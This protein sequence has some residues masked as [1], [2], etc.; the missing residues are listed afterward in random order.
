MTTQNTLLILTREQD[1]F[2]EKVKALNLPNLK[3]L[4]PQNEAEIAEQIGQANIFLANPLL[5]YKWI[6]KAT[7][8]EWMQSTFAG[9]DAINAP[10]LRKDY[11]L[12]NVKDTYGV[13]MAEYVMAYILTFHRELKHYQTQQ[14]DKNWIQKNTHSLEGKVLGILGA[15]SIGKKIAKRAKA[16]GMKIIGYKKSPT[17]VEHFDEIETGE[18]LK[19]LLSQADYVINVLPNTK[20][21]IHIINGKTLQQMKSSAIFM[22]IGRGSAVDEKAIVRA[23]ETDQIAKA[24]LDVFHV[25]PL[26]KDSPLW[27]TKNCIITPHISGYTLSNRVFEI[28]AENYMRFTKKEPLN[29][30]IDLKKGY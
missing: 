13:V 12:T 22:N 18:G 28:F 20:E 7:N 26:P 15:G 3:I 1:D 14:K 10:H 25:E 11:L 9:I 21:T 16:F 30:L 23:L 29:Y 8:L 24:I 6:N 4:V 27:T 2:H 5:A 17:S 19:N